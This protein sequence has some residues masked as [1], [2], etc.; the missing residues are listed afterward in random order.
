VGDP[1]PLLVL[2]KITMSRPWLRALPSA[3][4]TALV[5]VATA[6]PAAAQLRRIPAE[7]TPLVESDGVP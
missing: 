5:L 1:D 7:I 4:L 3:F 2:S 6:G